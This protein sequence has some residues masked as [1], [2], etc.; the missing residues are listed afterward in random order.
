MLYVGFAKK[1]ANLEKPRS[2]DKPMAA[3]PFVRIEITCYDWCEIAGH[4]SQ[5][6]GHGSQHRP[7]DA[8]EEEGEGDGRN[9]PTE[10]VFHHD[11]QDGK[12]LADEVG[13]QLQR[14]RHPH[15]VPPVVGMNYI[16]DYSRSQVLL[17][18]GRPRLQ[19]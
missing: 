7:D 10:T 9:G 12:G 2:H 1:L 18:Q 6:A 11:Q 15:D 8:A 17:S 19:L 16:G 3:I 4:L 13:G 5:E 14:R